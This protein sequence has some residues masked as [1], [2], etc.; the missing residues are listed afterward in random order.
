MNSQAS[1]QVAHF[2]ESEDKKIMLRFF[3]IQIMRVPVWV[4][5]NHIFLILKNMETNLYFKESWIILV[6]HQPQEYK[7]TNHNTNLLM[8]LKNVKGLEEKSNKEWKSNKKMFGNRS[9]LNQ[10]KRKNLPKRKKSKSKMNLLRFRKNPRMNQKRLVVR[11]SLKKSKLLL[12]RELYKGRNRIKRVQLKRIYIR[13]WFHPSLRINNKT[14]S[15][16][17]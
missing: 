17:S 6:T 16:L 8:K 15:N 11:M 7:R 14:V 12:K 5:N 13:I 9:Q 3:V 1:G 4:E 2:T 10:H